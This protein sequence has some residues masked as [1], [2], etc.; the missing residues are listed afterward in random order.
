[1][2]LRASYVTYYYSTCRLINTICQSVKLASDLIIVLYNK[3]SLNITKQSFSPVGSSWTSKGT[4]RV[5]TKYFSQ[6][7]LTSKTSVHRPRGRYIWGT[8]L[9]DRELSDWAEGGNLPSWSKIQQ[10]FS[11]QT[12]LCV[13][14]YQ[15]SMKKTTF[16]RKTDNFA[17]FSMWSCCVYISHS[18]W[19]IWTKGVFVL[20]QN[21]TRTRPSTCKITPWTFKSKVTKVFLAFFNWG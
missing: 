11:V 7:C 1:M 9:L 19:L 13:S 21:E 10:A 18:D 6:Y 12:Y 17:Y 16:C 4:L 14:F 15:F 2:I 3:T 8:F 5:T 20:H